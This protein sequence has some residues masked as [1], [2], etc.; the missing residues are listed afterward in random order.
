MNLVFLEYP[1][2]EKTKGVSSHTLTQTLILIYQ[3]QKKK[4][5]KKRVVPPVRIP[6]GA[7]IYPET[8]IWLRVVHFYL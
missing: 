3:L 1:Q 4:E 8:G 5:K 2:S 7:N 6:C